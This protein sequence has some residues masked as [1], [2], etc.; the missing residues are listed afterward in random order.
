MEEYENALEKRSICVKPLEAYVDCKT[1]ILHRCKIHNVEWYSTPDNVLRGHGCPQCLKDKIS[2]KNSKENETYL[3]ELK[4]KNPNVI[5]LSLYKGADKRIEHKC[6]K[7]GHVWKV[8]PSG[9]LSGKGCPKCR[10]SHGEMQV[11]NYLGALDLDFIREKRFDDCK[12]QRPLPFDFYIPLLNIC[13]E[14]D[15]AQHF[16]PVDFTGKNEEKSKE[17]FELT[18]K[19]D[20]I[21]NNYCRSKGI[22]LIRIPYYNNVE[23]ELDKYFK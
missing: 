18:K 5:A 22:K 21:K 14:Y 7:C 15:G 10:S 19:H 16:M 8:K 1:K 9:L 13:I 12:D 2:E 4:N 6:L 17:L 11:D 23:E 3:K 20:E